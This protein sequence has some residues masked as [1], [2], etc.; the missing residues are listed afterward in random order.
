M[1]TGALVS[2]KLVAWLVTGCLYSLRSEE[3]HFH[4]LLKL[5]WSWYEYD[6][7]CS[8]YR[9]MVLPV[10][11]S[12]VSKLC[13]ELFFS[14]A[15]GENKISSSKVL[16]SFINDDS[17]FSRSTLAICFALCNIASF[18]APASEFCCS[19]LLVA[20][21]KT[22]EWLILSLLVA[23]VKLV[24]LGERLELSIL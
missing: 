22:E 21:Y 8:A 1:N 17:S 24:L 2:G 10:N 5:D 19:W 6:G 3:Y 12:F 16:L 15:I 13:E 20:V 18:L 9:L 4:L 14:L 7:S 11:E 23:F